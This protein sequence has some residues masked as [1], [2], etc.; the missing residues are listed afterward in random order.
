MIKR[1]SLITLELISLFLLLPS[2]AHATVTHHYT[3]SDFSQLFNTTCSADVITFTAGVQSTAVDDPNA[4]ISF[5][6]DGTSDWY[7][8]VTYTETNAD[9]IGYWCTGTTF[10]CTT[11]SGYTDLANGVNTDLHLVTNPSE[12]TATGIAFYN[13]Y[14]GA[15]R[16]GGTLSDICIT[17]TVGGCNPTSP[18]A[19]STISSV[20]PFVD[21]YGTTIMWIGAGFLMIAGIKLAFD[22]LG[23]AHAKLKRPY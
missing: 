22:T 16:G 1:T 20:E 14:V 6:L 10:N 11:P 3:C 21:Q 2:I 19:S 15:N 13:D 9:H 8:T 12:P 17:D 5:N 4:G 18:T 23:A 7:L